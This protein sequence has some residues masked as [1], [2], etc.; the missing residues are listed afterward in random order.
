[1]RGP[2]EQQCVRCSRYGRLRGLL[3]LEIR[4]IGVDSASSRPACA[5]LV[6]VGEA[7]TLAIARHD[8]GEWRLTAF[9]W[10]SD[11][12]NT[13]DQEIVA[14]VWAIRVLAL[15]SLVTTI[16]IIANVFGWHG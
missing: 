2:N 10:S 16:V 15:V 4:R 14:C 3:P 1:M 11:P 7:T 6:R 8:I 12:T 5:A 13:G 9:I